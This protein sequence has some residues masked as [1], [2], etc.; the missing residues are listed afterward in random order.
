MKRITTIVLF[1]SIFAVTV[2]TLGL[3]GNSA[4]LV[5][6]VAPESPELVGM[7]GHVQ[8]KV[9]DNNGDVKAYMQ[10]DNVVVQDGSTC[11]ADRIFGTT[12]T[13]CNITSSFDRIAIGNGTIPDPLAVG[14]TNRTLADTDVSNVTLECAAI[15][16]TDGGEMARRTV[17]P[18]TLAASGANSGAVVTLETTIPF[19]FDG[20][21]A[22]S[23]MD[24]GVFNA[25]SAGQ[26]A[27]DDTCLTGDAGDAGAGGDWSMFS[28]Q[29]LNGDTGI[30][31]TAGDSLSVKWTITV[32]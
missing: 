8:Y 28:R 7:L 17:I 9:L 16:P 18:S 3:S 14:I 32:G 5:L 27:T 26:S 11:S 15:S 29:L 24:S 25:D 22:T 1:A 30:A 4:P 19:A 23:V 31:V 12:S 6:A 21:N 20:T 13:E 10:N 2:G